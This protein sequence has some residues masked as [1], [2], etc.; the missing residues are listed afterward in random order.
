MKWVWL[1]VCCA[2]AVELFMHA[3]PL[4]RA[5][6][7]AETAR[8]AAHVVASRRISDHWKERILPR[9]AR[10]LFVSSLWMFATVLLV[11]SPFVVVGLTVQ[12]FGVP[13]LHLAS[14]WQGVV[15]SCLIAVLYGRARAAFV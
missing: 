9:Y 15:A 2:F 11:L 4:D 6:Q 7:M 10:A 8:K 14:T 3:S 12:E 5:H 13:L 1:S